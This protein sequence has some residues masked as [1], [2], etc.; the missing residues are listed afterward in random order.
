MT[1]TEGLTAIFQKDPEA[2][3]ADDLARV[4]ARYREART[5]FKAVDQ[6]TGEPKKRRKAKAAPDPRQIDIEE[7]IA[8]E[9]ST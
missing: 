6:K 3:T 7:L 9:T 1:K 5:N 8:K 2:W 4:V